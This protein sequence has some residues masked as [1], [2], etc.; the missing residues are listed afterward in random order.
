M[1]ILVP[2][3]AGDS[4]IPK[5]VLDY[6]P[7]SR[8]R[9]G[10]SRQLRLTGI[11]IGIA[12]ALCCLGAVNWVLVSR[13]GPINHQRFLVPIVMFFALTVLGV[14][15]YLRTQRARNWIDQNDKWAEVSSLE[16][17]E[18][19]GTPR[20]R[21]PFASFRVRN[22][23]TP[24]VTGET[25]IPKWVLAR[26]TSSQDRKG[27]SLEIRQ[28]WFVAVGFLFLLFLCLM[29]F[30]ASIF[31]HGLRR[32]IFFLFC[33]LLLFWFFGLWKVIM[34]QRARTWLDRNQKWPEVAQLQWQGPPQS[35]P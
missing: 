29:W 1:V 17:Q 10:F 4:T 22:P 32:T 9:A 25:T 16:W 34:S 2:V 8:D 31:D 12:V 7:S 30:F 15:G 19:L 11:S 28:L 5:W 27:L 3:V 26:I 24:L 35:P 33:G 14:F 18:P 13:I 20:A 21:N 23:F 6:V